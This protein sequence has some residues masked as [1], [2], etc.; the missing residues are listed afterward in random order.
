MCR[1][2][3][4]VKM[5]DGSQSAGCRAD[6]EKLPDLCNMQPSFRWFEE[7][8]GGISTR[9]A[10]PVET[11]VLNEPEASTIR[12]NWVA[13]QPGLQFRLPGKRD[14]V[15]RTVH[16]Y[17]KTGDV[18]YV[19]CDT[20]KTQRGA[21]PEAEAEFAELKRLAQADRKNGKAYGQR[22]QQMRKE[23]LVV[24]VEEIR[25][26][27]AYLLDTTAQVFA[28]P[29]ARCRDGD[30]VCEFRRYADGSKFSNDYET[31][32]C[33]EPGLGHGGDAVSAS[34]LKAQRELIFRCGTI[35]VECTF[36]GAAGMSDEEAEREAIKRT[37]TSWTHLKPHVLANPQCCFVLVHFSR[38]YKDGDIKSYF[39]KERTEG[40]EFRNVVLWLDSGIID[41]ST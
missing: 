38:R 37:H 39:A 5:V 25:P 31:C 14:L 30:D 33:R 28:E 34:L 27:L 18:G 4:A 1:L 10:P 12:K 8:T 23:S 9:A 29:C 6:V 21:T 7:N 15:I 2:T 26:V 11:A 32:L 13:A 41:F 3:W 36:L 22:I 17:H 19:I 16:C 40:P 35:V 24:N 20:L